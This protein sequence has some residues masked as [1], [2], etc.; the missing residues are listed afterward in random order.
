MTVTEGIGYIAMAT[1][2]LS[3]MMKDINKLRVINIVG[4]LFF[5]AYGFLLKTSWP[6]I[7]TNVSIVFINLYYLFGLKKKV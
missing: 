3:F 7:I 1:I 2:L 5:V 6:I 4:C